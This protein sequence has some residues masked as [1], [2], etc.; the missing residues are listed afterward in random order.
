[1]LFVYLLIY[2]FFWQRFLNQQLPSTGMKVKEPQGSF[3]PWMLH[4]VLENR[5]EQGCLLMA[6]G[7]GE[8]NKT[9]QDRARLHSIVVVKLSFL[10]TSPLLG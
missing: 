6:C 10:V 5:G 9:E 7:R 3:H 1:M 4:W 8:Q 2:L